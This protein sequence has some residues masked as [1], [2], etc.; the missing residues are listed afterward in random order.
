MEA[1]IGVELTIRQLRAVLQVA[2]AE[3]FS[4][5]AEQL[6]VAQSSLS[7]AV[8]D[9]ERR[10]GARIFE[11][12]TRSVHLTAEGREFVLIARRVIGAYDSGMNHFSGYLRGSRGSVRLATLPSLAATLLPPI[13]VAFRAVAPDVEIHIVD[14]MLNDV[15]DHV[16]SGRVDFAITV[17]GEERDGL[18]AHEVATD[19]FF[20]VFPKGHRFGATKELR[21]QA[22]EGEPFIAFD[23][24]S[25]IRQNVDRALQNSSVRTGPV[26][27]ARNVA[28]VGGLV[29]AGL[30]VSA[31]PALVLPMLEFADL[32]SR[33]LVDPEAVRRI[34]LL[35]DPHR[36][37]A[38]A[39]QSFLRTVL[40]PSAEGRALP[41]GA[42]WVDSGRSQ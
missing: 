42:Q 9:T 6:R 25:S 14:G 22:L 36:P 2:D 39:C 19:R 13:V 21:W 40:S 32:D 23:T 3:S 17:M 31:V 8:A 35:L 29:A 38:P 30:G 1:R 24:T 15:L 27:E 20:A 11:R 41:L 10:I 37:Q 5:A 26:T 33:P 34:A 7:R 12:T 18:T 4:L 28:A 16:D